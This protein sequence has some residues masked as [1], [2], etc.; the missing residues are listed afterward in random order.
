KYTGCTIP[1]DR[2]QEVQEHFDRRAQVRRYDMS[3]A[4]I[5]ANIVTGVP[6]LNDGSIDIQAAIQALNAF[7]GDTLQR[8]AMERL[9]QLTKDDIAQTGVSGSDANTPAVMESIKRKVRTRF[10]EL[11]AVADGA[12]IN[13]KALRSLLPQ[14]FK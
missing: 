13:E 6:R 4:V 8:A 7:G 2:A 12:A 9:D 1:L 11:T 10:K 5:C 14:L 3:P